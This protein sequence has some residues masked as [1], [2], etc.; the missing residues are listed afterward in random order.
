MSRRSR[1]HAKKV[2]T[3]RLDSVGRFYGDYRAEIIFQCGRCKAMLWHA[4]ADLSEAQKLYAGDPPVGI[5]QP[6]LV[7]PTEEAAGI[8][9]YAHLHVP[10]FLMDDW[11]D[12]EGSEVQR[13]HCGHQA[14]I[15]RRRTYHRLLELWNE[16]ESA[17]EPRR[18][19]VDA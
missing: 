8:G 1:I 4:V 3:D 17:E 14:S 9:R 18:I 12:A 2:G 7:E 11:A 15:S 13:C 10:V 19:F 5:F 6:R 16:A